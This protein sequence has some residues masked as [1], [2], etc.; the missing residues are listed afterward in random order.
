[1]L[2]VCSW[3]ARYE[4]NDEEDLV[5]PQLKPLLARAVAMAAAEAPMRK[6]PVRKQG[7]KKNNQTITGTY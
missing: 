3:L 2:F 1:M 5:W 4:D 7:A 6:G